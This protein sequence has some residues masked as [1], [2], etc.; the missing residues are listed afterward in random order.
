[1]TRSHVP[2]AFRRTARYRSLVLV[3]LFSGC[4]TIPFGGDEEPD[5]TVH[6][7]NRSLYDVTV[8]LF[9]GGR[10]QRLGMVPAASER[11]FPVA[12]Q[13]ERSAGSANLAADPIGSDMVH[14]SPSFR[15]T[16][17]NELFWTL[18]P[19]LDQSALT[20]R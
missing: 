8:L 14:H 18:M 7:L 16:G 19:N 4:S 13:G 17:N 1:M 10:R 2:R 12:T 9:R 20:I 5:S 15:L 6:V 11:T 3:A